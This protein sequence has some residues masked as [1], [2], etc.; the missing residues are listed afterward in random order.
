MKC[1][2]IVVYKF[3][4]QSRY[5]MII[6]FWSKELWLLWLMLNDQTDFCMGFLETDNWYYH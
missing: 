4:F 5:Y 6:G 3:E 2:D 1:F